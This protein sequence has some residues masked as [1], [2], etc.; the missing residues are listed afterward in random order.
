MLKVKLLMIKFIVLLMSCLIPKMS[1]I[2]VL[3]GPINLANMETFR[4]LCHI[5]YTELMVL[6]KMFD[7]LYCL[8]L[9]LYRTTYNN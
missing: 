6:P 5:F 8:N 2:S 3:I 4:L 9:S 7:V 1:N